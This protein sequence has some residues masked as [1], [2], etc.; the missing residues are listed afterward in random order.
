MKKIFQIIMAALG[1]ITTVIA[2]AVGVAA[3]TGA[4]SDKPIQI[5]A[6]SFVESDFLV[7]DDFEMNFNYEPADA[8]E[9][10]I[11][12][13][14]VRGQSAVS[15]PSVVQANEPFAIELLKDTAGNNIGGEVE[16]T[17]SSGLAVASE[18][19]KFWIDVAIPQNGLIIANDSPSDI[20]TAGG[21]AFHIYVLTDP[22]LAIYPDSRM[23]DEFLLDEY[24]FKDIA[25]SSSNTSALQVINE[26]GENIIGYYNPSYETNNGDIF[27]TT[28]TVYNTIETRAKVFT[29]QAVSDDGGSV[30]VQASALRTY[31]M[32]EDFVDINDTKFS[33]SVDAYRAFSAYVDKYKDYIAAD[34]RTFTKE[35]VTYE[36]G[37]AFLEAVTQSD[38]VYIPGDGSGDTQYEAAMFYL[39][40][41]TTQ[42]FEIESVQISGITA[43]TSTVSIS[44]FDTWQLNRT[45]LVQKFGINLLA[46]DTSFTNEMKMAKLGSVQIDVYKGVDND[47]DNE[48]DRG[49][50]LDGNG[51]I[52]GDAELQALVLVR[53]TDE[54]LIT[55]PENQSVYDPA[56]PIWTIQSLNPQE[57]ATDGLRLRFSIQEEDVVY[58]ADVTMNVSLNEPGVI[59]MSLPDNFEMTINPTLNASMTEVQSYAL[60][61]DNFEIQ[62]EDP[63]YDVV[64]FFVLANTATTTTGKQVLRLSADYSATLLN[65][66]HMR[67][68][69]S[70][71]SAYEITYSDGLN[72]LLNAINVKNDDGLVSVF[73][74][75]IKTD[76][77]GEPIL[78]DEG[79]YIIVEK[80]D[81][82]S[83]GVTAYIEHLNFYTVNSETGVYTKRSAENG[84][85]TINLLSNH[86]YTFYVTNYELTDNGLFDETN[87]LYENREFIDYREN[88]LYALKKDAYG[89]D[90]DPKENI[91]FSKFLFSSVGDE[92]VLQ[93]EPG[94]GRETYTY[95]TDTDLIEI[96]LNV[97]PRTVELPTY[98][99]SVLPSFQYNLYAQYKGATTPLNLQTESTIGVNVVFAS[100]TDDIVI[101]NTSDITSGVI[102]VEATATQGVVQW[103]YDDN[104]V[105]DI[106][107]ISGVEFGYDI[108]AQENGVY[109]SSKIDVSYNT[110]TFVEGYY[111]SQP[112]GQGDYVKV[113]DQYTYV[114]DGNGNLIDD[115]GTWIIVDDGDGDYILEDPY[116]EYVGENNGNYSFVPGYLQKLKNDITIVRWESDKPD[117]MSVTYDTEGVPTFE[118]KKGTPTGELVTITVYIE[119]YED[120]NS[121]YLQQKTKTLQVLLVQEQ[122]QAYLYSIN[123]L[124]GI[125]EHLIENSSFYSFEMEGGSNFDLLQDV[126]PYSVYD[127]ETETEE[128]PEDTGETATK[129]IDVVFAGSNASIVGDLTFTIQQQSQSTPTIYF[130]ADAN[131]AEK[132][133]TIDP[134]LVQEENSSYHVVYLYSENIAT[135]SIQTILITDSFNNTYPYHILVRS[136]IDVVEPVN[137]NIT[138]NDSTQIDLNEDYQISQT[139]HTD[140]GDVVLRLP[141]TFELTGTNSSSFAELQEYSDVNS[142]YNVGDTITSDQLFVANTSGETYATLASVNTML[143]PY[144]VSDNK[145]VQI[146]LYYYVPQLQADGSFV[147]VTSTG[148]LLHY[149]E[150]LA[151]YATW[152]DT[153]Q[154]TETEYAGTK[155]YA[156]ELREYSASTLNSIIITPTIV[157]QKGDDISEPIQISSGVQTDLYQVKGDAAAPT[158]T[159]L[160]DVENVDSGVLLLPNGVV[161]DENYYFDY[162]DIYDNYFTLVPNTSGFTTEQLETYAMLGLT[163]NDGVISTNSINSDLIVPF[164][165]RLFE[166]ELVNGVPSITVASNIVIYVEFLNSVAFSVNNITVEEGTEY[167]T[168]LDATTGEAVG[169]VYQDINAVQDINGQ[170]TIVVQQQHYTLYDHANLIGENM[171]QLVGG[172]NED[173]FYEN[174]DSVLIQQFVDGAYIDYVPQTEIVS[175]TTS[176]VNDEMQ[177]VQLN[178][179]GAVNETTKFRVVFESG[180]FELQGYYYFQIE[181]EVV[182]V[183]TYPIYESEEVVIKN[184]T[185]NLHENYVEEANRI[186]LLYNGNIYELQTLSDIITLVN[187][188]N[189]FDTIEVVNSGGTSSLGVGYFDYYLLDSSKNMITSSAMIDGTFPRSASSYNNGTIVFN[190]NVNTAIYYIRIQLF[191]GAFYDYKFSLK[192]SVIVENIAVHDESSV[193]YTQNNPMAI[194][195][196]TSTNLFDVIDMTEGEYANLLVKYLDYETLA[197]TMDGAAQEMSANSYLAYNDTITFA[198]VNQ[199]T[200]VRFEIY[201]SKFVSGMEP[202]MLYVR[203]EPNFHVVNQV[204]N[205][206]AGDSVPLIYD[207]ADGGNGGVYYITGDAEGGISMQVLTIDGV[208]YD[209][210]NEY[211]VV[212][213]GTTLDTYNISNA[214][215][216][217][218]QITKTFDDGVVY[219]VTKTVVILPNLIISPNY[220]EGLNYELV[221][222]PAM[223]A[224]QSA[225]MLATLDFNEYDGTEISVS[226]NANI[227]VTFALVNASGDE[228]ASTAGIENFVA[229]GTFDIVPVNNTAYVYILVRFQWNTDVPAESDV[230]F[231][232]TYNLQIVPNLDSASVTYSDTGIKALQ[233]YA[234]VTLQLD[235][236]N[237]T[238]TVA[239]DGESIT[240]AAT[241]YNDQVLQDVM[242]VLLASSTSDYMLYEEMGS[243]YITFY[244]SS[245]DMQVVTIPIYFDLTGSYQGVQTMQATDFYASGLQLKFWLYPSVESAEL[246]TSYNTYEN[247]NTPMTVDF[248]DPTFV[249][250]ATAG[251]GSYNNVGGE[252]V[253]IGETGGDYDLVYNNLQYTYVGANNGDYSYSG[254]VY[255]YVGANLADY[256][257]LGVSQLDLFGLFNLTLNDTQKNT[258]LLLNS[259]TGIVVQE[260]YIRNSLVYS[261]TQG[262][263]YANITN[264][265]V[266]FLPASTL[267]TVAISIYLY[268]TDTTALTTLYFEVPAS[269]MLTSTETNSA[270]NS[271]TNR[272]VVN[273]TDS[274]NLY[275]YI[276]Y[277]YVLST[278]QDTESEVTEDII[279][280]DD[281]VTVVSRGVAGTT[282]TYLIS[283]VTSE[284]AALTVTSGSSVASILDGVLTFDA[285]N[286]TE[287]TNVSVSYSIGDFTGTM[288]F[289][290]LNAG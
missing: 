115:N 150:T 124:P 268:S 119:T 31:G 3:I 277:G 175:L 263:L 9:L 185:V 105:R 165:V 158:T 140:G 121:N 81:P 77:L 114:G 205:V 48:L 92:G 21:D 27:T 234:G 58:Y 196:N 251:Q 161:V 193:P 32:Q 246:I 287:T 210:N 230:V 172:Q 100:L 245:V 182:L 51:V 187:V 101:N 104:G 41:A 267:K 75:I 266:T 213:S 155:Y 204:N 60:T 126:G 191:N 194:S 222:A 38:S 29:V 6:L 125:G 18:T 13:R 2:G 22:R 147:Y 63:S 24:T 117:F 281:N 174:I 250:N 26:T 132:L 102:T 176:V 141:I 229:T 83:F 149:S 57:S 135:D 183:A 166:G 228:I 138:T 39:Y 28:K 244:Q 52:E 276:I 235:L 206:A 37:A 16:I 186:E 88:L 148:V 169:H 254:G 198:N 248:A 108:A 98:T 227:T 46:N 170:N 73:A 261:V 179:L 216:L 252:Y 221:T 15:V 237:N 34:T 109:T 224:T 284:F 279:V 258:T 143:T 264:G 4:F 262:S 188:E 36:N 118:I 123:T 35:T 61:E 111:V 82:V 10:D 259:G 103:L 253:Y 12:L 127:Y 79:N 84:T 139:L 96:I 156:F 236:E 200:V 8:N 49:V 94:N 65:M 173:L 71:T 7:I 226:G 218:I 203:V 53:T 249:L 55:N 107:D 152:D 214:I 25:I 243:Y 69:N 1:G 231:E 171:V 67:I 95:N 89:T 23:N 154:T 202:I 112:Q 66:T 270:S 238:P 68:A 265:V 87:A 290:V 189:A 257:V 184:T 64:K 40:V 181:P 220:E 168:S 130:K 146:K 14:V 142:P 272:Y 180:E 282:D 190:N 157:V 91:E 164:E 247:S 242:I 212:I 215:T 78:D 211:G 90:T 160:L 233:V 286:I 163:I 144:R 285:T 99:T 280:A 288:Y 54:F 232:T 74:A 275:D 162:S 19:L 133:Y 283:N 17:A 241:Q 20:L 201:G 128:N 33:T 116:F 97:V 217:E 199:D 72:V 289:S 195:A 47:N 136:N 113:E 271:S 153:E 11:S 197:V 106:F 70:I 159:D 177:I 62:N 131:S 44:L 260:E 122:P 269:G 273:D 219:S 208:A 207:S 137:T 225:D 76:Y 43:T 80:S 178:L 167:D 30:V 86:S 129:L 151:A 134:I 278:T 93:I 255:T 56:N 120:E 59:T 209:V 5:E 256:D 274:I 192:P 45:E 145:Q 223:N 240:V 239:L 42:E 50:D 85:G 110:A